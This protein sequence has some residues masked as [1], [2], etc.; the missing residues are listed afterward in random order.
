ML[1]KALQAHGQVRE[2]DL[3]YNSLSDNGLCTLC[4]YL[5]VTC[6]SSRRGREGICVCVWDLDLLGASYPPKLAVG[7]G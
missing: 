1:V 4:D 5:K 2:L 3:S 7:L 6:F